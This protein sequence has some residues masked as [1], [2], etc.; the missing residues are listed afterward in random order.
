MLR[1]DETGSQY[2]ACWFENGLEGQ[3]IW[4]KIW[5]L[6]TA[7]GLLVQKWPGGSDLAGLIGKV[8][9]MGTG[10]CGQ[11]Y[12]WGRSAVT[13]ASPLALKG[14]REA[15]DGKWCLPPI[16]MVLQGCRVFVSE[17]QNDPNRL[18]TNSSCNVLQDSINNMYDTI[19]L[20]LHTNTNSNVVQDSIKNTCNIIL[21]YTTINCT[22][23]VNVERNKSQKN[24]DTNIEDSVRYIAE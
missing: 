11:I 14:R 10:Q 7:L 23:N 6:L 18:H 1:N 8:D 22:Y 17:K 4:W 15:G 9:P 24:S 21:L 20:W 5:N 16:L 12:G 13:E 2:L 19:L 3:V